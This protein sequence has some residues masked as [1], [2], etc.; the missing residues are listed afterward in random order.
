M[1]EK[2]GDM[3]KDTQH[4]ANRSNLSRLQSWDEGVDPD[5][6]NVW[7]FRELVRRKTCFKRTKSVGFEGLSL[8]GGAFG[9]PDFENSKV[10]FRV[11]CISKAKTPNCPNLPDNKQQP[12]YLN[13]I[14]RKIW[15]SQTFE[16]CG[17]DD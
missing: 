16:L 13:K 11:Q 6:W 7:V 12:L 4:R 17:V 8:G 10:N 5:F 2:G 14:G 1:R 3:V 15:I 9:N